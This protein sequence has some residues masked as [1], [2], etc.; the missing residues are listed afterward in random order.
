MPQ[1]TRIILG[2][3]DWGQS[4]TINDPGELLFEMK[5]Y[6]SSILAFKSTI[7]NI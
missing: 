4:I 2:I 3:L 1:R 7:E 5:F 6:K